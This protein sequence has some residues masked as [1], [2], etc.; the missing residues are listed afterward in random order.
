MPAQLYLSA[1][2][3]IKGRISYLHAMACRT[4][5]VDSVCLETGKDAMMETAGN[6]TF[7]VVQ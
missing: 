5:E 7:E 4:R 1:K 2:G 3:E 6:E